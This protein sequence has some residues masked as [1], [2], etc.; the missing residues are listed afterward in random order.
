MALSYPC[1]EGILNK[2][3]QIIFSVF[4]HKALLVWSSLAAFCVFLV[5]WVVV[6]FIIVLFFEPLAG[7][8]SPKMWSIHSIPT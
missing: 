5:C 8:D 3:L 7:P 2:S 4:V 6:L 1:H